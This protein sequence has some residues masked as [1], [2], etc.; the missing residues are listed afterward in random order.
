MKV[1]AILKTKGSRVAITRPYRTIE[2]VAHRL[3]MENVGALVVS[4]D[5]KTV[6]G[7]ISE[8]NIIQE[9]AAH[10]PVL[11]N[12]RVEEIMSRGIPTCSPADALDKVM[13]RMTREQVRHLP[14]IQDG[15]LVGIISIG[16][17][18]KSRLD[19]IE[20]ETKMLRD[21]HVAGHLRGAE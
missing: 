4:R 13:R 6:L 12:M 14:V 8:R 9:L 2:V 17:V 3:K 15:Q 7:M 1:A 20:L 10:G 11:L 18:V 19:E 16:D 5:D 21:A